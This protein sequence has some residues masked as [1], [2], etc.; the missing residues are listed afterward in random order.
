LQG[1]LGLEVFRASGVTTQRKKLPSWEERTGEQNLFPGAGP[2][3]AKAGIAGSAR[4]KEERVKLTNSA[5]KL[6]GRTWEKSLP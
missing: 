6:G 4:R 5:K 2:Q 1:P 3:G